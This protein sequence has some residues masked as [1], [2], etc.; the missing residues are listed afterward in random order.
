M[1]NEP[2]S[3]GY[4]RL[5]FVGQ[6]PDKL[7]FLPA[8]DAETLVVMSDRRLAAL[9]HFQRAGEVLVVLE[10]SLDPL[11]SERTERN[12]ALIQSLAGSGHIGLV[13]NARS[14][15]PDSLKQ[16]IRDSGSILYYPEE[17]G[18]AESG[19]EDPAARTA[20]FSSPLSDLA[21]L[22]ALVRDFAAPDASLHFCNFDREFLAMERHGP[23]SFREGFRRLADEGFEVSLHNCSFKLFDRL[24]VLAEVD[25]DE[26]FEVEVSLIVPLYNGEGYIEQTLQSVVDQDF[27]SLEVVI[28]DDGS[29][30]RSPELARA[31]EN[32]FR[33]FTY[34][35]QENQ[36]VS[37]ARNHGLEVAAGKY[38]G[39]LDA[40]DLLLPDSIRRRVDF[41]ESD[42]FRVCGGL[43][44]IVDDSGRSL[45][46]TVGRRAHSG[47]ENVFEV[48]CQ[49]STLMGHS[50]VMKRQQFRVG[51]RF[52]ED[53]RYM[54]DLAAAGE[55]IGFCG[56]EPLSCYR[57]H[58]VSATGKEF[59]SHLEA[60]VELTGDLVLKGQDE[61]AGT[62][63]AEDVTAIEGAKARRHVIARIH[64]LC[65]NVGIRSSGEGLDQRV[66]DLMNG[67]EA[68]YP[69][70][71]PSA[72]FENTFTRAFL[73]PRYS[74]ELHLRIS[75]VAP[76]LLTKL[77]SLAPTPANQIFE[78]SFRSYIEDIDKGLAK[79]G[80]K[81]SRP[82]RFSLFKRRGKS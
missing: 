63:L 47:Y 3:A 77:K 79:Q 38:I 21:F 12:S 13:F 24:K 1:A 31:F 72:F 51:Q 39:F 14:D 65:I 36:G 17:A 46:L 10:D 64:S 15:V 43:T 7:Q 69:E 82:G 81:V 20:R 23:K 6:A 78:R 18:L 26:R 11:A 80:H 58:A 16:A 67:I 49:I 32:R 2:G 28:V 52:A 41:L 27:E 61:A 4:K 37:A 59:L 68:D 48:P 70:K 35:R 54:V 76:S 60:C 25:P 40:D 22:H 73:L 57:W 34:R 62:R 42:A 29:M 53:W 56:E 9:G 55:R 74:E 75:S 66:L 33:R 50:R 44:M 19:T 30:D 45:N 71:I 5:L 8:R